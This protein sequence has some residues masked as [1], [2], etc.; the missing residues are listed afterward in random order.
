MLLGG[1]MLIAMQVMFW[2]TAG[3][4][5]KFITNAGNRTFVQNSLMLSP[6]ITHSGCLKIFIHSIHL[7]LHLN[8]VTTYSNS[9]L[10]RIK[11]ILEAWLL[12]MSSCAPRGLSCDTIVITL[13][14]LHRFIIITCVKFNGIT[15]CSIGNITQ[16]HLSVY[17]IQSTTVTAR[18]WTTPNRGWACRSHTCTVRRTIIS[19]IAAFFVCTLSFVIWDAICNDLIE[20]F[21]KPYYL[22][23]GQPPYVPDTLFDVE[24]SK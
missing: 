17:V 11:M 15:F 2:K 20:I 12:P 16:M 5:K 18:F 14:S 3:I 22:L 10:A 21:H 6:G 4:F 1:S 24:S 13:D 8:D 23:L 19:I 7:V 9:T